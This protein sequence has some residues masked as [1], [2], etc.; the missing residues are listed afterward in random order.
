MDATRAMNILQIFQVT[1]QRDHVSC[2]VLVTS[3]EDINTAQSPPVTLIV[4][5]WDPTSKLSAEHSDPT[6]DTEPEPELETNI[7][8]VFLSWPLNQENALVK[9]HDGLFPA[10]HITQSTVTQSIIVLFPVP[11]HQ[12]ST[13]IGFLKTQRRPSLGPNKPSLWLWKPMD[14]LQ[15]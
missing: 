14:C 4:E 10:L 3:A 12:P 7:R 2:C 8:K 5:L 11:Y 13:S 9:L 15:L 1:I 6:S